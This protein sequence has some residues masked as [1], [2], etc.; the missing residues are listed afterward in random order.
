M[1]LTAD[2]PAAAPR[3]PGAGAGALATIVSALLAG[4]FMLVAA[5]AGL[6]GAPLQANDGGVNRSV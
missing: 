5:V 3:G 1:A 2:T 4:M 6:G